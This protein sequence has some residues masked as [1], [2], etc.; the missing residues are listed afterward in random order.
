[1]EKM[2][3][4]KEKLK[5]LGE[6]F[7]KLPTWQKAC[8]VGGSG[9]LLFF[10]FQRRG[11]ADT[12]SSDDLVVNYP[13]PGM[14]YE[15]SIYDMN[16]GITGGIGGDGS[17]GV[18]TDWD[19]FFNSSWNKEFDNLFSSGSGNAGA[20]SSW[21][22]V[23]DKG[24]DLEY[25]PKREIFT[26]EPEEEANFFTT[27]KSNPNYNL[28]AAQLAY[29]SATTQAERE[30]AARAGEQARNAGATDAGALAIW[31][32]NS[33]GSSGGGS[34]YNPNQA[35]YKA[36]LAYGNAKTAAERAAAERAGQAARKNG[37]T[38]AGANA[39]WQSQSSGSGKTSS[40]KSS[41]S[42]V[43]A[44]GGSNSSSGI[45][46]A[47][48]AL[49]KAQAAYGAAKTSAER[50]AAAKAGEAARKAG[51]TDKGAQAAWKSAK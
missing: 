19:N 37:A 29:G 18:A 49:Q 46:S 33:S 43:K 17:A 36:Q 51:A 13:Y 31:Q 25:S 9:L 10:L 38:D 34:S 2:E 11:G 20:G 35:L 50:A 1:M 26:K 28:Y 6:K 23:E 32:A 30:A 16:N 7:S 3:N 4:L 8:I 12:Y 45:S 41:S 21:G 24:V 27:T 42:S 44:S 14:N 40:S 15:D 48:R 47:D 22:F 5:E 39:I